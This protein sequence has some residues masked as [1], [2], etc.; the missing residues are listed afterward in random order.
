MAHAFHGLLLSPFLDRYQNELSMLK[1]IGQLSGGHPNLVRYIGVFRSPFPKVADC[2]VL[3]YCDGGTLHSLVKSPPGV[4]VWMISMLSTPDAFVPRC[5]EG[6]CHETPQTFQLFVQLVSAVE[7]LHK[8]NIVHM[9]ISLNNIL[10]SATHRVKKGRV[11]STTIDRAAA[12]QSNDA[13][14]VMRLLC[15]FQPRV[16]RRTHGLC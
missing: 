12:S 15:R 6:T 11:K 7:Y 4:S 9:D 1:G 13:L 2:L 10:V 8:C 16:P 5:S 3:G 14:L